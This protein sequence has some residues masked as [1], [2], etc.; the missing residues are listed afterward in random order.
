[1]HWVA[2]AILITLV[3]AIVIAAGMKRIDILSMP[4]FVAVM[5]AFLYVWLPIS[6][7]NQEH[8]Y[9]LISPSQLTWAIFFPTVVLFAFC[10]GWFAHP[11]GMR[12]PASPAVAIND[13]S[14]LARLYCAGVLLALG[15]LA[16]WAYFL[17]FSG[18]ALRFY[19]SVHGQEGKWDQA[20]AWIYGGPF[21]VFPGLSFMLISLLRRKSSPKKMWIAPILASALMFLHAILMG[22]RGIFFP[23]TV[24]LV[25][26]TLLVTN[27][28]PRFG[29]TLLGV[30]VLG[31]CVFGLVIYRSAL[32]LDSSVEEFQA[33]SDVEQR[34]S[35][36]HAL[37]G[38]EFI[39]HAGV[40]ATVDTLDR[41]GW[42]ERYI[43][44][45]IFKPFPRIWWSSKPS[46]LF[47]VGI[48]SIEDVRRVMGWH[49]SLG[50]APTLVADWYREWGVGS[51]LVWV[52]LGAVL[53]RSY[54]WAVQPDASPMMIVLY[55]SILGRSLHFF[56]QGFI[57]FFEPLLIIIVAAYVTYG[58]CRYWPV[59]GRE[60]AI[61]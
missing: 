4:F 61:C 45:L 23:L 30:G 39:Y 32:H 24:T 52:I 31:V 58:L 11:P 15:G 9:R 48:I 21:L 2:L 19:S 57:A 1:M 10:L 34:T 12:Q 25:A 35:V 41:H 38:N 13:P 51:V 44:Y 16:L 40:L 56:A 59:R 47:K 8:A 7:F 5:F 18:G 49:V 33:L 53:R 29:V 46:H 14:S 36:F 17:S 22:S 50:S 42:G 60:L 28:R 3:G 54:G 20:S 37:E 27:R 6:L 26:T 43:W 55:V